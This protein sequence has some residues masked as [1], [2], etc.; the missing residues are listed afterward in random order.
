MGRILAVLML[1]V[2]SALLGSASWVLFHPSVTPFLVPGATD[3]Q[4]VSTGI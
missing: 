3:I 4:V 2:S 1:L